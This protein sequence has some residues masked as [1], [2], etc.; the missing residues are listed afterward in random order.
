MLLIY[1]TFDC[2][3]GSLTNI[4]A[5]FGSLLCGPLM[6]AVGQ[7][8][9]LMLSLP[10][11]ALGWVAH[12]FSSAIWQLQV[13]RFIHGIIVGIYLPATLNYS[14]EISHVN[15]RGRMAASIS[16]GR[17]SGYLA[18]YVIGS[19]LHWR[20]ASLVF[21]VVTLVPFVMLFM[22][23]DSP[24]WLASKSRHD[25]ARKSLLHFRGENYPVDKELMEIEEQLKTTEAGRV[26]DQ[27]KN[28]N[29]PVIRNLMLLM[30]FLFF[31]SQLNGHNSMATY[32]TTI[33]QSVQGDID[34]YLSTAIVGSVRVVGTAVYLIIADKFPRKVL[35]VGSLGLSS[36]SMIILGVF[37]F[38][39]NNGFDVSNYNYIPIVTITIYTCFACIAYTLLLL[40]RS[41]L[42]PNPV[43][44]LGVSA[45]GCVYYVSGFIISYVF[46]LMLEFMGTH[47]T[48]IFYGLSGF[49]MLII[50]ALF[51]KETYSKSL[52]EIETSYISNKSKENRNI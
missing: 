15:A 13:I 45:I 37:L 18:S 38:F 43:R 16:M 42:L 34:S 19:V 29:D 25:D 31:V 35:L 41:E 48:F 30:I 47:G 52:E 46:L 44:S 27:V 24:R 50:T 12:Y 4:G 8:K 17:Q 5:I 14:T 11:G 9:A 32:A 23:D 21:G 6:V 36:A 7:R 20:H 49:L 22:L 2:C 3:A 40:V 26:I 33:F 28:F 10:M 51:V 39:S 1:Y